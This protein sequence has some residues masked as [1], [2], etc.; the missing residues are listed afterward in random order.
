MCLRRFSHPTQHR[1][2]PRNRISGVDLPWK[3]PGTP[4]PKTFLWAFNFAVVT[5][6]DARQSYKIDYPGQTYQ[7][8]AVAE[9]TDMTDAAKGPKAVNCV[10]MSRP[11][12]MDTAD[13]AKQT[14][15]FFG[16]IGLRAYGMRFAKIDGQEPPEEE[17]RIIVPR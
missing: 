14:M 4:K 11:L 13:H 7:H 10:L 1:L 2:M 15:E 3:N 16:S 5:A 6:E 17:P 12:S 9:I 8:V